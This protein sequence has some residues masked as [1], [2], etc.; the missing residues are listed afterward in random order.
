VRP[1]YRDPSQPIL[2]RMPT[3]SGRRPG[4][5]R[6]ASAATQRALRVGATHG[7]PLY[8][9]A[10]FGR[11]Y[12]SGL[13]AEPVGRLPGAYFD[14]RTGR[15]QLSL[16]LSTLTAIRNAL[17]WEPK[18]LAACCTDD[19]MRWA[20][21]AKRSEDRV[22]EMHK[23]LGEGWRISFPWKDTRAG[24]FAPP[25]APR[26]RNGV[27][28]IGEDGRWLYREPYE[29]QRV[30]GTVA[31]H[32]DGVLFL[33]EMGTSKTRPAIDA[34]A[35]HMRHGNVDLLFVVC[36]NRVKNTW[37]KE[38]GT[39]T[40]EL[41]LLLLSGT[42]A[43]RKRMIRNAPARGAVC[44]LNYEVLRHL[45]DD[46]IA[47]ARAGR[48]IGFILDEI[49]NVRNPTTKMARAAQEIAPIASWRLGMS[50]SPVLQGV[51][52]VWGQWYVIDLGI[53]FGANYVQF[54][55]EFVDE[56]PYTFEQ[57]AAAGALSEVGL[58]MRRRGLRY[59]KEDCLDL[60]PKV[61]ETQNVD[62]T[63][64]QADAYQQMADQLV[65]LLRGDDGAAPG[66]ADDDLGG[67]L[68]GDAKVATA[69]TQLSMI[70]RL[71]Q[72]T[73][74]FLPTEEHGVHLFEP[75]P[76]MDLLEELVRDNV[77]NQQI[78]VWARYR[79]DI[80]A[81]LHRLRDLNPVVI[82]GGV[83]EKKA[84]EAEEL[85]Q[86]GRSRVAVLNPASASEGITFSAASLALY[87][88]QDYS[89]KHR[90]QSEDRCHRPGSEIHNRVTY[91]D[92][93][94]TGTVDEVVREALAG[95]LAVAEAV[96]ELRA[97]L[98]GRGR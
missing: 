72:I 28:V 82:Y 18:Q 59:R 11:L 37:R 13:Y 20:T 78:L 77:V 91:V 58:R 14:E 45:K 6:R 79:R 69:A 16:T 93:V 74:G 44:V 47:A 43:E 53:T 60:P 7:K 3:P 85:F 2:S 31:A 92:L 88:S 30:M 15:Y 66:D 46:I 97:H 34:A 84:A 52:D 73:S 24:T 26:F 41:R 29:H 86:S 90:L 65:A 32:L 75:N 23:R 95:K 76:K 4:P 33:A 61:H 51:H 83:S 62:M 10:A 64:E 25:E 12:V 35:H 21:A 8:V 5:Q 98:E 17:G 1:A 55:R 9:E 63:R 96:V 70:L 94:C 71:S 27:R 68:A 40:D 49:H 42:V 67:A 56:D 81:I 36:P 22:T 39:W 19:V 54:R 87:Y 80:E 50:G 38:V 89:L 48:K 57:R